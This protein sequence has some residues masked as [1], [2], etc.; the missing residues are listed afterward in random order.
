MR[1]GGRAADCETRLGSSATA[2]PASN[3]ARYYRAQDLSGG[4]TTGVCCQKTVEAEALVSAGVTDVLL[5]NEV[6]DDAKAARLA[7]LAAAGAR[8]G[9]LVDSAPGA[10]L[11]SRAATAAGATLAVLVELDVGQ[12]RCGVPSAAAAVALCEVVAALPGLQLRGIQAYHGASQHVRTAA[13]R[14]AIVTRTAELAREARDAIVERGLSC[15][16]V[17]G[18][19]TGTFLDDAATGVFTELQPGSY[20]FSDADYA[21]N[22]GPDG[23]EVRSNA[24]MR[25]ATR[26]QH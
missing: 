5:S 11:L 9:V 2:R 8:I 6:V 7:R 4:L 13:E 12:A 26:F 17:T 23:N 3:H 18:G 15:D 19:G 24:R 1:P 25:S 21:R 14:R 16:V 20:V 22:L 10:E